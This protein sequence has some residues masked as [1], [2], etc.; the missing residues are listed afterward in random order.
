MATSKW[1]KP[2]VNLHKTAA[3]GGTDAIIAADQAYDYTS[4]INLDI[5]G[6]LGVQFD[7][8]FRAS[9]SSVLYAYDEL[10]VNV[11]ASL[12]GSNFDTKPYETFRYKSDGTPQRVTFIVEGPVHFRLGLKSAGTNTSFQY[13]LNYRT[14]LLSSGVMASPSVS[15]SV[16]PSESPSVSPST[17]PSS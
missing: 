8:A 2:T 7:L 15:P 10:I 13:D 14:W 6:D 3:Y 11:F 1:W 5:Y 4:N 16:S 9:K 17:S 12:D